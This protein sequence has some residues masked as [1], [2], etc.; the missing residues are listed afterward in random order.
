MPRA[1]APV[2]VIKKTPGPDNCALL[3]PSQV[4]AETGGN[5]R[6]HTRAVMYYSIETKN[7]KG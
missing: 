5:S 6:R 3:T 7:P 4:T 1:S 2:I